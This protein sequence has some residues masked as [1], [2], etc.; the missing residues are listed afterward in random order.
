MVTLEPIWKDPQG[1]ISAMSAAREI[2]GVKKELRER[3]PGKS[4]SKPVSKSRAKGLS[5]EPMHHTMTNVA[6]AL[7]KTSTQAIQIIA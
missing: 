1:E 6:S 2:K 4:D 7:N 5:V 3:Q